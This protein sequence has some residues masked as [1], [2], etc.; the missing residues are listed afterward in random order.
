MARAGPTL[1]EA[2]AV[3]AETQAAAELTPWANA[4]AEAVE[5]ALPE[6]E[7]EAERGQQNEVRHW[8]V[9]F[10]G[11]QP[12]A[13]YAAQVVAV[14]GAG[15]ESAALPLCMA[16]DAPDACATE[17]AV[18]EQ[19]VE[20]CGR[21]LGY[22]EADLNQCRVIVLSVVSGVG[23]LVALVVACTARCQ[24]RRRCAQRKARAP[25]AARDEAAQATGTAG[26]ALPDAPALPPA[27][28]TAQVLPPRGS[29]PRR[30]AAFVRPIWRALVEQQHSSRGVEDGGRGMRREKPTSV[31]RVAEIAPQ[32]RQPPVEPGSVTV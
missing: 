2:Q 17:A 3:G 7:A 28:P 11:L 5:M 24:A 4:T 8:S 12:G 19:L 15:D 27:A 20:W 22:N 13:R 21:W 30:H 9:L 1:A 16:M 23:A 25:R 29:T 31:A 26:V 32:H 18:P 6:V 14:N 10:E